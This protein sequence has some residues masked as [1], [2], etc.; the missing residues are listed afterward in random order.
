M[1]RWGESASKLFSLWDGQL[2]H[3]YRVIKKTYLNVGLFS[4]N[5][6]KWI[7]PKPKLYGSNNFRFTEPLTFELSTVTDFKLPYDIYY[8]K[9]YIINVIWK[10][11]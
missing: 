9:N 7:F 3:I 10:F 2:S 1:R 6:T 4:T 11:N 5:L 8:W